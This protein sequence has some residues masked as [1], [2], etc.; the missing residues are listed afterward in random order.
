M[1]YV[2]TVLPENFFDSPTRL[3]HPP[4]V[5]DSPSSSSFQTFSSKTLA[6]LSLAVS[7]YHRSSGYSSTSNV[8][9][10]ENTKLAFA[11]APLHMAYAL[12]S[13]KLI[14]FPHK[15]ATSATNLLTD[16][17]SNQKSTFCHSNIGLR[18]GSLS[19]KAKQRSLTPLTIRRRSFSSRIN[20]T[21]ISPI[22]SNKDEA[23]INNNVVNFRQDNSSRFSNFLSRRLRNSR[24]M[25][26]K[27]KKQNQIQE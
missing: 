7:R 12:K 13:D 18:K 9:H 10:N 23:L 3:E 19:P 17:Y 1:F 27:P 8:S 5:F 2:F 11:T 25:T 4:I 15:I 22:K 26:E 14:S 24:I 20:P 16:T 21:D 6:T